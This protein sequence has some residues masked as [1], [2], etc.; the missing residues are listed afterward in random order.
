M[1]TTLSAKDIAEEALR[2]IGR[3]PSTQDQADAG[4][5]KKSLRMLEIILQDRFGQGSMT[6]AWGTVRVP[7]TASTQIY[8]LKNQQTDA[9]INGVQFVYA[10]E[11]I[12]IASGESCP[13]DVINEKKFFERDQNCVGR[14]CAVY[15]NK[16]PD[17]ANELMLINPILG[18]EVADG[19]YEIYLQ[20]QTFATTISQNG[21]GAKL[22]NIR[23]TYYL[24]AIKKLA[25]ELG[26]GTLRQLPT[27]ELNR[28]Q[29]DYMLDEAKLD[30]FDGRENDS[31]PYT[32]PWG[33]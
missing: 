12:T 14:P 5:L 30:A 18:A 20:V 1:P 31:Q 7:L 29:K 9:A 8:P 23:P 22:I 17:S 24:W 4:D 19:T 15:I 16:G 28:L 25:Y 10:A 13:I 26:N 33:Q 21:V 32:R 2:K 6:S 11:L 3:F 27:A